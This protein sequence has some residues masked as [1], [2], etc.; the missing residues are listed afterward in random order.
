MSRGNGETRDGLQGGMTER[1]AR[2]LVRV[3]P[4]RRVYAVGDIHGRIDL[5]RRLNA[6]IRADADAARADSSA[7]V[8][9]GDYV[10]RGACSRDVLDCLIEDPIPGFE[11][12]RLLGNHEAFLLEFLDDPARGD[13]WVY[14]GGD[15]TLRDYGVDPENP[16]FRAGGWK[17]LRDRFLEVLP[18][19][20]LDFLRGLPL[21][22][23]EGDYVFVH[24]GIRPGV[25]LEKQERRDLLWI[26]EGFLDCEDDLGKV[27]VHGHTPSKGIQVRPNRIGIDTGAWMSDT[28][29]CVVLHDGERAFIQT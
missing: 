10:D 5:L 8:Y 23:I 19:R 28:L 22:H 21:T 12:V 4:G 2:S 24:A 15:A 27:V 13:I 14:N 7:V 9:L 6:R 3:P 11:T 26:R 18:E 1:S 17:G 29:T 16:E 25:P 20:H